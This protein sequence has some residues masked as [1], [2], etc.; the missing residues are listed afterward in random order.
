MT[1]I[2]RA[3]GAAF[4]A[5]GYIMSYLDELSQGGGGVEARA[6]EAHSPDTRIL[7]G[8]GFVILFG[9]NLPIP[10]YNFQ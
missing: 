10:G 9:T 6:V 3:A 7:P 4:R 5:C 2:L 8:G 1:E